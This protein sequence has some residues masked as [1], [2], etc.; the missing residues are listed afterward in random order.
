MDADGDGYSDSY[1]Y[2]RSQ[3]ALMG[4]NPSASIITFAWP[5]LVF[6]ISLS[7]SRYSKMTKKQSV[8]LV[9]LFEEEGDI[10][11]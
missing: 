10:N 4:S 1:G 11:A 7:F 6:L 8:L 3:L 2:A 5:M 9:E